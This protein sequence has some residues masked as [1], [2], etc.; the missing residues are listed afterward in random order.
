MPS[1]NAEVRV[2]GLTAK[3]QQ[4]NQRLIATGEQIRQMTIE[5][6]GLRREEASVTHELERAKAAARVKAA[7]EERGQ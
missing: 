5:V 7:R 4:I 1:D 6:T 2:Q 3:L